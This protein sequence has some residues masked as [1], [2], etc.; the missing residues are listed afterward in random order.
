M[1]APRCP[2]CDAPLVEITVT[3][4]GSE[5]TM[6]SCS[7]CDQR[8]WVSHGRQVDLDGVLSDLQVE[9]RRT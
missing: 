2:R 6:R 5:A 1:P 9:P 7:T 8:T 4:A 3:L